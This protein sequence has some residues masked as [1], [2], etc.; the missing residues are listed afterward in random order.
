MIPWYLS[1]LNLWDMKLSSG[2][3]F[4]WVEYSFLSIKIKVKNYKDLK[5]FMKIPYKMVLML[6]VWV[7]WLFNMTPGLQWFEPCVSFHYYMASKETRWY[8]SIKNI[9]YWIFGGMV[10][11]ILPQCSGD[12]LLFL[13]CGQI[14][15][16][17][18]VNDW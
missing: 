2:D 11:Y 6:I 4:M 14:V 1:E 15:W 7:A 18:S 10:K 13:A 12:Q 5:L 17:V 8:H 9:G 16:K 3:S